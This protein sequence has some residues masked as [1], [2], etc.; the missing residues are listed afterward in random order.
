MC[1]C[2]HPAEKAHFPSNK[3]SRLP[4]S[5]DI[6]LEVPLTPRA[7]G[8]SKINHIQSIN[9]SKSIKSSQSVNQSITFF[10]PITHFVQHPQL[11]IRRKNQKT[12]IFSPSVWSHGVTLLEPSSSSSSSSASSNII[13]HPKQ[14]TCLSP[15]AAACARSLSLLFSQLL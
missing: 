12:N 1:P 4:R 13:N 14:R 9:Q 10:L 15:L 2:D 3:P 5:L 8:R 6:V 7:V 11:F